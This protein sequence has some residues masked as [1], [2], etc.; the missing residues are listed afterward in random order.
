MR[1][2]QPLHVVTCISNPVRYASRWRLYRRFAE[3]MRTA[4]VHLVTVELAYGERPFE[5]TEVGN[6]DH[7][8]VRLP[9]S[10]ELWHKENLLNLGISRLPRDWRYVAWIDADIE[11]HNPDWA[12]ETVE[13]L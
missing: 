6:P 4:G 10:D 9:S 8:Q 5:V 13:Q 12:K 3:T 7:V 2:D 11:F 1:P